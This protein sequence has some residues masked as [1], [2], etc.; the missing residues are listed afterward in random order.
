MLFVAGVAAAAQAPVQRTVYVTAAAPDGSELQALLEDDL[1]VKENGHRRR[2]LRVEP[3]RG[4]LQVAIVVEEL[5]APDDDVRRSIANFIDQL[6]DS[7][8]LALY[9]AGRR[10]ERRVNYTSDAVAFANAINRFPPRSV[11]R[12]DMVQ[13]LHEIA[14]EQRAREGRR[15]LVAIAVE[16]AQAS[17]V[18]ASAVIEQ[19]TAGRTVLYAA[20]LAGS[21]VSSIPSGATSGGRRLDL[22]GQVSGLE[23]DRLF[24]D[25]TRQSGG[26]HIS[27]QRT[28]GLWTALG[29]FAAELRHQYVVSYESDPTSDGTVTIDAARSGLTIRGPMRVR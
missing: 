1:V 25:G 4:T 24:S 18:T 10:A 16:G 14:K 13:A 23:R 19:L 6:R 27:S 26:A 21:E 17:S 9:V 11:E 3:S 2:V 5:L 8:E 28:A 12:G 7:G 20:T 29:R 15:A 22:E